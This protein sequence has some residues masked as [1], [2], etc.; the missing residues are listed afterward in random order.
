MTEGFAESFRRG[1][2]SAALKPMGDLGASQAT[3]GAPGPD[4][5]HYP[6]ARPVRLGWRR[7][8]SG[9]WTYD[10]QDEHRWEVFCAQ[11]GDSDGP[12]TDQAAEVQRLRGPYPGKRRAKHAADKHFRAFSRRP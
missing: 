8:A 4:P 9:H 12:A 11:C 7:D 1:F 6:Y 2:E 5:G 3:A 10:A